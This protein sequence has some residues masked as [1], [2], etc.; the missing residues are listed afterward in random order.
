[1]L[2]TR[3]RASILAAM[4]S[5]NAGLST[6]CLVC[7][8]S[9]AGCA[10]S[11]AGCAANLDGAGQPTDAAASAPADLT[12]VAPP[13]DFAGPRAT[14]PDLAPSGLGPPYPIVLVH[15][16]AGFRNIGPIDY[17]YG[18]PAALKKDG[19]D[20]WISQQDPINDSEVRGPE[21]VA[22]VQMV[23]AA[24]GKAKVN[25]IGHSQGGFDVRFVAA[26]L[27]DRV[28][29]VI[30]IASPMKGSPVADLAVGG[31]QNAKDAVNALLNLYG[32]LNG[33]DSDAKSQIRMLTSV[34]AAAF[35]A[36]HPDD[37]RVAYYSIAGRSESA[38]DEGDCV[39]PDAPEF[40]SRW[41]FDLDPLDPLL[42]IPG[43]LIDQAVNP[44]PIHD[45][46]VVVASAKHG[47]F[48]GCI[49]ADHLQEV[50]QLFGAAPGQGNHFD[51]VAFYREMAD[52][53]VLNG[54]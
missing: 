9:L 8:A 30:T 14:S 49:P 29:S 15:G 4:F 23:L 6:A 50:N 35:F 43:G 45:G 22:F 5:Q 10:V 41:N 3:E 40:V 54:D 21:V 38:P 17:F 7:A 42:S 16:M 48:L 1:M 2:T 52:W 25:L 32:A 11:L 44:K 13:E 28:A 53:L 12:W 34:G 27:G 19:H 20:V 46:L 26:T 39:A 37:P 51:A 18:I 31:G 47:H 24:T 36:Q 33:Y